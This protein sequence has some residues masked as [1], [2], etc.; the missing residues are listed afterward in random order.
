[1]REQR[2]SWSVSSGPRIVRALFLGTALAALGVSLAAASKEQQQAPRAAT[3]IRAISISPRGSDVAVT[4][5]GNGV[6]PQ[7]T[8]GVVDGPPRIFL[9]FPNI[10]P[11]TPTVTQSSDPRIRRVRAGY[12]TATP[13]VT[14]VVIDL[15]ASQTHRVEQ[16]PGLIRIVIVGQ[17]APTSSGLQPVPQLPDPDPPPAPPRTLKPTPSLP[18][19]SAAPPPTATTSRPAQSPTPVAPLPEL[20]PSPSSPPPPEK[21]PSPTPLPR[22]LPPPAPGASAQPP[23]VRDLEKYRRQVSGALDRFR[24]QQPLLMSL[25]ARED[26]TVDRVRM[27]VEEFDRLRQE[28]AAV[29]PPDTVRAQHDMLIQSSTLAL[30]ATRLRLESLRTADATMVRNAA[31]AAAGAIL[32]LDRACADLGCPDPPGR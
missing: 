15:T 6:L 8:V 17:G 19:P 7:P 14:R 28:L 5:L 1:M 4:I 27:A 18:P 10:M 32:L 30:M 31:S 11:R 29:K 23:P 21:V 9:D 26:Q 24:L 3:A 20:G 22:S 25:D 12:H 16:E 2:L 13:L